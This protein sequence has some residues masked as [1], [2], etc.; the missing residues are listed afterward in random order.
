MRQILGC[1]VLAFLFVVL[2][3]ATALS[4]PYQ[5]NPL[6]W[7]PDD[8]Y[9][10]YPGVQLGL[11]QT[12]IDG[13]QVDICSDIFPTTAYMVVERWNDA[14]NFDA[15]RFQY[16]CNPVDVYIQTED[17]YSLCPPIKGSDPPRYPHACAALQGAS[18]GPPNYSVGF[19]LV[20]LN[21]DGHD[22]I[23]WQDGNDSHTL[24]D[25]THEVG[26]A[27]GMGERYDCSAGATVMDTTENCWYELPQSLDVA[28]YHTL[29]HADHVQNLTGS[30]PSAGTV[31]LE[32]DQKIPGDPYGRDIPNEASFGVWLQQG[33][34]WVY[35]ALVGKNAEEAT[36]GGQTPGEQWYKVCS[37]TYADNQHNPISEC[38]SPINVQVSG[39]ATPT[40]TPTP[41]PPPAPSSIS[42]EFEWLSGYGVWANKLS[43]PSVSGA[44]HY[45]ICTDE[46]RTGSYSTCYDAPGTYYHWAIPTDDDHDHYYKVKACTSSNQCSGLTTDWAQTQR[47]NVDG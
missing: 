7:Y 45:H 43:W 37:N 13:D 24:R 15:F 32:W 44:D 3:V 46:N 4:N 30:S 5:G 42:S 29:Y 8:E 39:S 20:E 38:T 34:N 16:D 41:T 27:V 2:G 25:V 18:V 1:V 40:P 9:P 17:F 28:N 33:S 21:P 31:H 47:S 23:P 22:G 10:E 19:T 26:H 36:F 35:Q 12:W 11:N 14:L 6:D